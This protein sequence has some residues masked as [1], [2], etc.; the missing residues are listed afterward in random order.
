MLCDV[1]GVRL[2]M[3]LSMCVRACVREHLD[4]MGWMGWDGMG[5]DEVG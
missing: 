1:G 5:W 2:S 3:C 4:E